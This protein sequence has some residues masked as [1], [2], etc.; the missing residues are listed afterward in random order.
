MPTDIRP[1]LSKRNK[2]YIERERY[3]ELRHFCLQYDYW[4]S[5]CKKISY[6]I[7]S[8]S[9]AT[10]LEHDAQSDPTANDAL[11]RLEYE[12]KIKMI[13]DTAKET[14]ESLHTYIIASVTKGFPYQYLSLSLGM[15]ACRDTFYDR[16]RKFFWLLSKKRK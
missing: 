3:Y 7:P 4:K 9:I 8:S 13:D 14:D 1:E 5:M 6:R 15:P 12:E 2:W 10:S 16:Y 11:N